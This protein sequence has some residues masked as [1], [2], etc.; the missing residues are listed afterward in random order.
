MKKITILAA[1]LGS[2]YTASAQVGIGTPEPVTSAEL[3][4]LST[5]RGVLIPR[6]SLTD[7]TVFAPIE[8][9][10]A[11]S[12]LIYNTNEVKEKDILKGFYYWTTD[13]GG[14]WNRIVS[15]AELT[16][17]I[18][19]LGGNVTK[20]E[21]DVKNIQDVINYIVPSN[22]DNKDGVKQG[23]TTIVFD[24]VKNEFKYVTYNSTENKYETK[25]VDMEDMVIKEETKTFFR[26]LE[27]S[28]D[29]KTKKYLFFSETT[30]QNWLGLKGNEGKKEE[31]VPNDAPGVVSID[32]IGDISGNI[33]NFFS[34]KTTVNKEG[35][36]SEF[37]TIEELIK[38]MS[39]KVDGNV[40]YQ[41][42]GVE[43]KAN[44]EFKFFK[45]GKYETI[46]LKDLI[47]STETTTVVVP[48]VKNGNT[49]GYKYFNEVAVKAFLATNSGKT[50]TD[51][52]GDTE[53]GVLVDVVG[54]IVN[55]FNDILNQEVTEG[56]KKYKVG[57][58]ISKYINKGGNVYYGAT[59]E[60]KADV[61][62][63]IDENGGK[64]E[65]NFDFI[66]NYI[67]NNVEKIKNI[68]GDHISS[69]SKAI[70]NTGN[71]IN[72][73]KVYKFMGTTNIEK[74]NSAKTSGV[75]IP[76]GAKVGSVVSIQ[77]LKGEMLKT[78]STTD[79]K[80]VGNK[81]EF[82]IGSGNQYYMI[83]KDTYNVIVEFTEQ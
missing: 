60:G 34:S 14:Q 42:T 54:D 27:A 7:L 23:H 17:V 77:V 57:D 9:E 83:G 12:L 8:G 21:G 64:K 71:T 56:D 40:I 16:T 33:N 29:N 66:S 39:T 35:S 13:K 74:V 65:I 58:L 46:N 15:K 36:T 51:I 41:N 47:S 37:Y 38:N 28:G 63:Q 30:I 73:H 48:V 25:D 20:L 6:I 3:E 62:Y 75:L 31:D 78:T 1:L 11:E 82:N 32:V 72:G 79:I 26:I 43:G 81:L 24:P 68:L 2:M 55:N 80:V 59:A 61:F 49:I 52:K 76:E 10:R 50:A 67:T 5:N 19:N 70:I 69:T 22:P 44:W 4:I 18:E 45:E 53:G